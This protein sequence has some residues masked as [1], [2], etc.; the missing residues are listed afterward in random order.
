[1]AQGLGLDE[2]GTLADQW[3]TSGRVWGGWGWCVCVVVVVVG[4]GGATTA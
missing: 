1:M 3:L 2:P 4:G